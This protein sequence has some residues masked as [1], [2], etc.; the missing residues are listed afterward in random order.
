MLASEWLPGQQ[1]SGG[2]ADTNQINTNGQLEYGNAAERGNLHV[3]LGRV[4]GEKCRIVWRPPQRVS[5]G[6]TGMVA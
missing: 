5:A 3:H 1:S 6:L 4:R 2:P